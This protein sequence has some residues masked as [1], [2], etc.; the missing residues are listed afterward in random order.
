MQFFISLLKGIVNQQKVYLRATAKAHAR[1]RL[2]LKQSAMYF[3]PK[4]WIR[5]GLSLHH[6]SITR[7]WQSRKFKEKYTSFHHPLLFMKLMY[8]F[9]YPQRD[10]LFLTLQWMCVLSYRKKKHTQGIPEFFL[11]KSLMLKRS[12]NFKI[13]INNQQFNKWNRQRVSNIAIYVVFDV[14]N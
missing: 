8:T 4:R 9:F 11:I 2:A 6:L 13:L 3:S 5:T 7:G 12:K 1:Y 14:A 10:L